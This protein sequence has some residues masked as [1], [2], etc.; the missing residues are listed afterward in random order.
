MCSFCNEGVSATLLT[1]RHNG[2]QGLFKL[3]EP[4]FFLLRAQQVQRARHPLVAHI[5]S[6]QKPQQLKEITF[7]E[8]GK[9]QQA[10]IAVEE[11]AAAMRPVAHLVVQNKIDTVFQQSLR[12]STSS[13]FGNERNAL[14][15]FRYA[16]KTGVS[17]VA[18][19]ISAIWIGGRSLEISVVKALVHGEKTDRFFYHLRR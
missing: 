4:I 9:R 5:F 10:N 7:I 1:H 2:V 11:L 19:V 3:P 18:G 13:T 12:I 17:S 8:I 6:C 14:E 15:Q 16:P